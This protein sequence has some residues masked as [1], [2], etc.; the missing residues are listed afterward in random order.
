MS[1]TSNPGEITPGTSQALPLWIPTTDGTTT[2]LPM[3]SS[4]IA[5]I[6]GVIIPV[7]VVTIIII[8]TIVV[9]LLWR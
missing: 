9:I 6:T 5:V 3:E 4:S 8:V 7:L 2:Q 1:Q